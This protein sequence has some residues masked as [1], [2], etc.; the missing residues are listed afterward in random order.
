MKKVIIILSIVALIAGGCGQT[1]KKPV[2]TENNTIVE[3][4]QDKIVF[5]SDVPV[6][7]IEYD[8]EIPLLENVN[9]IMIDHSYCKKNKGVK[10]ITH[11]DSEY[12]K[13]G[14]TKL[15]NGMSDDHFVYDDMSNSFSIIAKIKWYD[16]IHS[17][18]IRGRWED[19]TR[20]WIV[21]YDKNNIQEDFY[22]YIDSYL[23]GFYYDDMGEGWTYSVVYIQSKPYIECETDSW[24]NVEENKIEIL[25][26]GEFT[27]IETIHSKYEI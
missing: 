22:A 15:K 7:I 4:T 8:T 1:S 12:S 16:H 21:N 13:Y 24:G 2:S 11:S 26:T 9:T 18:I 17:L 6:N 20:I 10:K 25:Q 3:E 23:I 5:D 27:V 19:L 14:I